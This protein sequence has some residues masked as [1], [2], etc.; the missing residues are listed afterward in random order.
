M[1]RIEITSHPREAAE[2]RPGY[3]HAAGTLCWVRFKGG[4]DSWKLESCEGNQAISFDYLPMG[5]LPRYRYEPEPGDECEALFSGLWTGLK[6]YD[7]WIPGEG[8]KPGMS[9]SAYVTKLEVCPDPPI[10]TAY[11][12]IANVTTVNGTLWTGEEQPAQPE[13]KPGDTRP[14]HSM[15][16]T[17]WWPTSDYAQR[18]ENGRTQVW[19][20]WTKAS[21]CSS[22]TQRWMFGTVPVSQNE[23]PYCVALPAS[24]PQLATPY[25][26]DAHGWPMK[27]PAA[28]PVAERGLPRLT[29]DRLNRLI[30]ADRNSIAIKVLAHRA[31]TEPLEDYNESISGFG[32]NFRNFSADML[33]IAKMCDEL[34][35]LESALATL[36]E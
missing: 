8:W 18:G 3:V 29:R 21:P 33:F 35:E 36:A 1:K 31:V 32:D 19:W 16:P 14:R 26:W 24:T 6:V 15:V 11:R 28:E 22:D 12:P 2:P 17:G 20:N 5:A 34:A 27:E 30:V 23:Q 7:W 25:D 4:R 13:P 10:P 9:I